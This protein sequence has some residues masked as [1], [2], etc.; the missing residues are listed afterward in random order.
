[1]EKT[2]ESRALV[3]IAAFYRHDGEYLD[4]VV[5]FLTD[6]LAE[7][8][9][10]LALVPTDKLRLLRDALGPDADRVEMSYM[11]EV[12]RN[13]AKTFAMF[14]DA[15]DRNRDKRVWAVAEPVWPFRSPDEYPACVQNE[16]LFNEAF[17]AR[18]ARVLCPYDIA[19]LPAA[20]IA[21]ARR[22]HPLIR[23]GHCVS[24]SAEHSWQQAWADYN[25]PLHTDPDA[26]TY[27]IPDLTDL[28]AA[29]AFAAGHA[30]AAGLSEERIADLHLIITELA[31]NSLKYTG[32]NCRLALW[33]RDGKLVCEVR[34]GGRLDDKLAGRRPA[35][36]AAIG[37]RGL[38]L[39]N[40]LADLVLMHTSDTGTTIQAQLP[41]EPAEVLM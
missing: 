8:D 16:A 17:A 10:A 2:A 12:G 37:G 28:R 36:A 25:Q 21:D 19:R 38:L 9:P 23:D 41:L 13:P 24:R 32:T 4:T 29:R 35:A 34:D 15:L 26:A 33:R 20:A 6:G 40:A 27:W 22:T 31:T 11:S 14:A 1:M 18:D 30:R 3:H 5:P 39:V 7:G